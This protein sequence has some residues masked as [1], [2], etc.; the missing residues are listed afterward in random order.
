MS[1]E[2]NKG[3]ILFY[4][5]NVPY[6]CCFYVMSILG[7]SDEIRRRPILLML[8]NSVPMYTALPTRCSTTWRLV[9]WHTCIFFSAALHSGF[10]N[11]G[12][13]GFRIGGEGMSG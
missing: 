4:I 3:K 6:G 2:L 12:E 9:C 1:G 5:G 8:K 10:Q 13:G 7:L 11:R